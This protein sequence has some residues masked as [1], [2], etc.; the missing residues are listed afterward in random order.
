MKYLCGFAV[1]HDILK[2]LT[3]NVKQNSKESES[4]YDNS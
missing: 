4:M 1:F 2:L 3:V